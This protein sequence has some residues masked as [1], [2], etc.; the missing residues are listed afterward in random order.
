MPLLIVVVTN[1]L[2][3]FSLSG[4]SNPAFDEKND[5]NNQAAMVSVGVVASTKY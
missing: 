1:R 2:T 4:F 3:S 5:L